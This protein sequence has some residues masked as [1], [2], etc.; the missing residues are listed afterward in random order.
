[1]EDETILLCG[2]D[3]SEAGSR[4]TIIKLNKDGSYNQNFGQDGKFIINI[5]PTIPS[6]PPGS[7][8]CYKLIIL[9]DGKI[10]AAGATNT[11]SYL[12]KLNSDGS[13]DEEFGFGGIVEH[14]YPNSDFAIQN[15]GKIIVGGTNYLSAY[16]FIFSITR[17]NADGSLDY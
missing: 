6:M 2:S 11:G 9:D 4:S 7:E 13:L 14:N 17:F 5:D 16:N 12:M 1:M 8:H 3:I 15:N 10:L